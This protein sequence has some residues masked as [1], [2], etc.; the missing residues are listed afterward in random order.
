[1]RLMITAMYAQPG[2]QNK[3]KPAKDLQANLWFLTDI[4]RKKSW[5]EPHQ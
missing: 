2:M 1:M 5:K 4:V 3:T